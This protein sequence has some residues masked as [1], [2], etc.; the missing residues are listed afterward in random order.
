MQVRVL[1]IEPMQEALHYSV[2]VA[3]GDIERTFV[4]SV[5]P[6]YR[7]GA[8]YS[9]FL[10]EGNSALY[11]FVRDL[12]VID[13]EILKLVAQCHKGEVVNFQ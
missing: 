1:L 8:P 2:S 12:R 3:V 4:I 11:H 6:F 10:V 5:V 9:A 7:N 13:T